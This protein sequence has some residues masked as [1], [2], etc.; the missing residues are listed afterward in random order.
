M[1]N[2]FALVKL[3]STSGP[4]FTN[5]SLLF[6][7]LLPSVARLDRA[8]P[9]AD[10][11][12][13][14]TSALR[15]SLA[16]GL[17]APSTAAG[18][19]AEDDG[20]EWPPLPRPAPIGAAPGIDPRGQ[21]FRQ[22]LR[23]L[24]FRMLS[25]LCT[26]P[27]SSDAAWAAAASCLS[28]LVTHEGSVVRS[29]VEELPLEAVAALLRQ[30]REHAW[31]DSLRC[32][33]SVLAVNLLY[34]TSEGVS[35]KSAMG[36]NVASNT[37]RSTT[38][39]S[40]T[41]SGIDYARLQAFGGIHAIIEG[42]LQ[43][44]T[45][46]SQRAFFCVMFDYLTSV[47][48]SI[49]GGGIG[50]L[51]DSQMEASLA[52]V[53]SHL[54]VVHKSQIDA[55]GA[56]LFYSRAAEALHSVLQLPFEASLEETAEVISH[57]I[58]AAHVAHPHA[59]VQPPPDLLE[60]CLHA[61]HNMVLASTT[62][63]ASSLVGEGHGNG[64]SD[65]GGLLF[66]DLVNALK[67]GTNTSSA[68]A[69]GRSSGEALLIRVLIEA[70]NK[71]VL[72]A[73]ASGNQPKGMLPVSTTL[74]GS[75]TNSP[76]PPRKH[77]TS[78]NSLLE[79]YIISGEN[80]NDSLTAALVDALPD[81]TGNA[82]IS[83]GNAVHA[84][85]DY[86][87]LATNGLADNDT[88]PDLSSAWLAV[89]FPALALNTLSLAVEWL[90]IAPAAARQRAMVVFA[91]RTVSTLTIRYVDSS[92]LHGRNAALLNRKLKQ[93]RNLNNGATVATREDH[94]KD[95]ATKASN[96]PKKQSSSLSVGPGDKAGPSTLHLDGDRGRRGGAETPETP[97][98]PPPGHAVSAGHAASELSTKPQS[99]LNK[100]VAPGKNFVAAWKRLTGPHGAPAARPGGVADDASGLEP[101]ELSRP[102]SAGLPAISNNNPP[103]SISAS[104]GIP[105]P[106]PPQS[107]AQHADSGTQ[108]QTSQ[109]AQHA[110]QQ[111]Q[112]LRPRLSSHGG[113]TLLGLASHR[114]A[115]ERQAT[116]N[117]AKGKAIALSLAEMKLTA[118]ES[119]LAGLSQSPPAIL[120]HVPPTLLRGMFTALRPDSL[121]GWGGGPSSNASPPL[122]PSSAGKLSL[123]GVPAPGSNRISPAQMQAQA[124]LAAIQAGRPA[125]DARAAVAILLLQ[126]QH[127]MYL[128]QENEG[129]S[130]EKKDI[131]KNS[132]GGG[133]VDSAVLMI[134]SSFLAALLSDSDPRVRRHA[135]CFILAQFAQRHVQQYRNAVREVV[136]KAQRG[137]D[138]RLLRSPEAQVISMLES[139]LLT[140]ESLM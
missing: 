77:T 127:L 101:P 44:P 24:L 39:M 88:N 46:K 80:L 128:L 85:L 33:L 140:L 32:W 41:I 89:D 18:T 130:N 129:D 51:E 103:V 132:S 107:T 42:Y 120:R 13:T 121:P 119:F 91:E 50:I 90:S 76:S 48:G 16:A 110:K 112:Q 123:A 40:S 43:A 15:A 82:T 96:D 93:G 92:D 133:G 72:S 8:G 31:P 17:D 23:L 84:V 7:I 11:R 117:A 27:N 20:A 35:K 28:A 58:A 4:I 106:S 98:T 5:D 26:V 29:F 125:W 134:D 49:S 54:R 139:R 69:N 22:W 75:K 137:D 57:Q 95:T 56:A 83:F 38:A 79:N 81:P 108:R 30:A 12:H 115:A 55:I 122:P 135:S 100:L 2:N 78:Q 60:N 102:L 118:V 116:A 105:P 62:M 10:W 131:I 86:A 97:S 114:V 99:P 45:L 53:R 52:Q 34:H 87:Q 65:Q 6:S 71:E 19:A 64:A 104:R 73:I 70:A 113:P 63:A 66:N 61:L 3:K 111:Q 59:I 21:R 9:S 1:N 68:Q 74:P 67:E 124:R 25:V 138:E 94:R 47:S 136:A 36:D 14:V 126:H 109:H 37:N